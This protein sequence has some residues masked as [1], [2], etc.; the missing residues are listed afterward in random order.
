MSDGINRLTGAGVNRLTEFQKGM[1]D[2]THVTS[3]IK[4]TVYA[5]PNSGFGGHT[6]TGFVARSKIGDTKRDIHD[7][8]KSYVGKDAANKL[9]DKFGVQRFNST[10][11]GWGKFGFTINNDRFSPNGKAITK[12]ELGSM[13][14]EAKREKAQQM[15]VGTPVEKRTELQSRLSQMSPLEVMGDT[16]LAP[17][18]QLWAE[19]ELAGENLPFIKLCSEYKQLLAEYDALEQQYTGQDGQVRDTDNVLAAKVNELRAKATEIKDSANTGDVNVSAPSLRTL[20]RT[21]KRSPIGQMGIQDLRKL[22]EGNNPNRADQNTGPI[23]TM[24]RHMTSNTQNSLDRLVSAFGSRNADVSAEKTQDADAAYTR[25]TGL[26]NNMSADEHLRLKGDTLYTKASHGA[27]GDGVFNHSKTHFWAKFGNTARAEKFQGAKEK[28]QQIVA[29]AI[30]DAGAAAKIMQ[31]FLKSS[32][33]LSQADLSRILKQADAFKLMGSKID[34]LIKSDR[35]NVPST[36]MMLREGQADDDEA[37]KSDASWGD[38][39]SDFC[40]SKGS[41]AFKPAQEITK[42]RVMIRDAVDSDGNM[43]AAASRQKKLMAG[44][45]AREVLKQSGL[46]NDLREQLT[47]FRRTMADPDAR[48][49]NRSIVSLQQNLARRRAE[50]TGGGSEVGKLHEEFTQHVAQLKQ[51]QMRQ[52]VGFGRMI[53]VPV[54][55]SDDN[56]GAANIENAPIASGMAPDPTLAAR[57]ANINASLPSSQP[58]S[59]PSSQPQQAQ[60][61]AGLA[62]LGAESVD[63]ESVDQFL[64]EQIAKFDKA[65]SD[66][67][68][69]L[70][71]KSVSTSNS[72]S[73]GVD[74]NKLVRD[75][76][77]VRF[78]QVGLNRNAP[79]FENC[80]QQIV[81]LVDAKIEN[82]SDVAFPGVFGDEDIQQTI[83]DSLRNEAAIRT[84]DPNGVRQGI[85]HLENYLTTNVQNGL[86]G[87]S[88]SE[89]VGAVDELV[90]LAAAALEKGDTQLASKILLKAN[91]QAISLVS[92]AIITGALS[93]AGDSNSSPSDFGSSNVKVDMV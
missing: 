86:F 49:D 44:G 40:D 81:K 2:N 9:F 11:V 64:D 90:A 29:A 18:F 15:I 35:P 37:I 85:E 10:R 93:E 38:A 92:Q 33:A 54:E 3:S 57:I 17:K 59:I 88:F 73:S 6:E 91:E 75:Q 48:I 56:S 71:V 16:E 79:T 43:D 72:G 89:A 45:M 47:S 62:G 12:D 66:S 28:V 4:K 32:R 65:M 70:S 74:T 34:T 1:D 41:D 20:N 76:L 53:D 83:K 51:P 31:P 27:K 36:A 19:A 46:P 58:Q 84:D 63:L 26:R 7:A 25:L 77:A 61:L 24:D 22:Y 87:D 5:K 50:I 60:G 55:P 69:S 39:F 78:E 14:S 82:G 68:E 42:L 21:A 80:A 13:L 30:G 23:G 67:G 52:V 8:L